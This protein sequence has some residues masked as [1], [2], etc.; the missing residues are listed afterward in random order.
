MNLNELTVIVPT[1]N[2][3][4]NIPPP[5]W[6]LPKSARLLVNKSSSGRLQSEK[7][8]LALLAQPHGDGC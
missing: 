6:V 2:E 7:R 5:Q 8:C 1:R 4:K 3:E